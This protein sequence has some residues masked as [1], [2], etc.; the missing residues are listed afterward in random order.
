MAVLFM[1][2]RVRDKILQHYNFTFDFL[3]K[4]KTL[5]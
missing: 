1:L 3:E 2:V 4:H 5:K